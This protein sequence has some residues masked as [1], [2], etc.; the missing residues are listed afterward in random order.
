MQFHKL[1][2]S[3]LFQQGLQRLKLGLE[4][5]FTIALMCAEKDAATCHRSL[6]VGYY[7]QRH[8]Q[9]ILERRE[10][11]ISHIDHDGETESQCELEA[12]VL[13]LHDQGMDLFMGEEER[14]QC[15]Y[16]VQLEKTSY[17]KPAE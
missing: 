15:A 16:E 7:L 1:M 13:Q 17:I 4:K 3:A 2:Q 14:K 10:L 11:T 8:P 9:A 12:R 6:L 5:K